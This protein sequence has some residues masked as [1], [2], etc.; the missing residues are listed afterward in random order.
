MGQNVAGI[1]LR[2]AAF[3][4]LPVESV[5]RSGHFEKTVREFGAFR[6]GRRYNDIG[7]SHRHVPLALLAKGSY[8]VADKLMRRYPAQAVHGKGEGGVLE[9]GEMTACAYMTQQTAHL[10]RRFIREKV[11]SRNVAVTEFCRSG[12]NSIRPGREGEKEDA[13]AHTAHFLSEKEG[14]EA[15]S[16]LSYSA[17][18]FWP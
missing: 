2:N 8:S 18:S 11:R 7:L 16:S 9:R 15:P 3:D 4:E 1:L 12:D 10:L 14:T 17:L 5:R 13:A 6:N